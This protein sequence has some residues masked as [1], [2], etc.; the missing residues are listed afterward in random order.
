[1]PNSP[2]KY[3][4]RSLTRLDSL[5]TEAAPLPPNCSPKYSAMFPSSTS[6]SSIRVTIQTKNKKGQQITKLVVL[7]KFTL[8]DLIASTSK[9]LAMKVS[10]LKTQKGE[11][12]TT[13]EQVVNL[14]N[15]CI[16]IAV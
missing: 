11:E 3:G 1:M 7:D 15:D 12:L 13:D 9:K 16:L 4:H 6:R 8:E 10:K 14:S 5:D 2:N